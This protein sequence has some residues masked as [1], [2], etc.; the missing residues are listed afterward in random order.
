ASLC[1]SVSAF[2]GHCSLRE[3][4]FYAT[5]TPPR[6]TIPFHFPPAGGKLYEVFCN[7]LKKEGEPIGS[8]SLS[9]IPLIPWR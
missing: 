9:L 2:G 4:C 1:A 5:Y 8:P 6:K 7:K 3:R